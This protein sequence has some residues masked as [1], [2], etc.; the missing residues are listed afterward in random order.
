[1]EDKKSWNLNKCQSLFLGTGRGDVRWQKVAGA[2]CGHSLMWIAPVL[3]LVILICLLD[4]HPR[5]LRK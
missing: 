1:M 3:A 5:T 4:A 2:A